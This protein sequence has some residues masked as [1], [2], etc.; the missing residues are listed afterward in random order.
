MAKKISKSNKK[1]K[2]T[3]SSSID[4]TI[5]EGK[6]FVKRSDKLLRVRKAKQTASKTLPS[7]Q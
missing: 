2:L 1:Q 7:L 3:R 5:H 4:K 6:D